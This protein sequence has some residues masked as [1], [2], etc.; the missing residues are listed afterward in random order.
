MGRE[1]EVDATTNPNQKRSRLFLEPVT[2]RLTPKRRAF[3]LL[4]LGLCALAA[5]TVFRLQDYYRLAQSRTAVTRADSAFRATEALR[6]SLLDAETGQRGYLLTGLPKYLAPYDLAVAQMPKVLLEFRQNLAPYRGERSHVRRV[7]ELVMDKLRELS[8]ALAVYREQGPAAAFELVREGKGKILMD[9]LRDE[10]D[11]V[12]TRVFASA[13]R[14]TSEI[15][16]RSRLGVLVTLTG[17]VIAFFV[18]LSG[19]I[20]LNRAFSRDAERLSQ[21]A[22]SEEAFRLLANRLQAVREEERAS[23]AREIHDALGGALTGIKLDLSAVA[24]RL[25]LGEHDAAIAR[26]HESS[27]AVDESIRSLRRIAS[28]LRPPLIDHLGLAAAVDA[29]AREFAQRLGVSLSLDIQAPD[30]LLSPDARIALFRI[31][32]ESFTN[33]A[34]HAKASAISLSLLHREGEVTIEIKDN[35]QGFSTQEVED[36]RSFGLLGI[37]ERARLRGAVMSVDSA[38]GQGTTVYVSYPVPAVGAN[39]VHG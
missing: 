18:L 5:V 13:A 7:E 10:S 28:E 20:Q 1:Y 23:L 8:N 30:L 11:A 29:F 17:A 33:I 27:A 37:R 4:V 9:Q 32:Q 38:S 19:T 26:L 6:E 2:A 39:E 21:I 36:R 3:A 31:V 25:R 12:L 16:A 24:S 22:R 14:H 35:G 34:R 15:E